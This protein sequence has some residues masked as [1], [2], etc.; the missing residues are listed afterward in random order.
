[1]RGPDGALIGFAK[2]SRDI[3]ERRRIERSLQESEARFRLVIEGVVDNAI[4]M[5][6]TEGRVTGWNSGAE[7]ILGYRA[8]EAT[9][10]P[11][12]YFHLEEDAA[13]GEPDRLLALSAAVGSYHAE[14]WRRRKD[15]SR[16]GP[17]SSSPRCAMP[18]GSCLASLRSRATSPS[19]RWRR[20]SANCWSTRRRAAC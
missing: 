13:A 12:A 6:D 20:N 9:G 5:L 8:E 18:T 16:S 14:G 4:I 10:L 3:T 11:I 19:A 1:M 7:R 15:G 2:V 17:A